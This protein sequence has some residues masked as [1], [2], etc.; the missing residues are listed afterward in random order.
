MNKMSFFKGMGVGLVVGSVV[1]MTAMPKKSK[2][3][4]VGKALRSMGDAV[5][6]VACSLGL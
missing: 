5:E 3:G 4:A 2:T 1:G 6:S